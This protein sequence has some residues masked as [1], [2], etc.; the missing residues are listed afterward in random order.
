MR[1]AESDGVKICLSEE[2]KKQISSYER[3]KEAL[4]KYR[5]SWQQR[6]EGFYETET[7]KPG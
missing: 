6:K 2:Q 3:I 1:F 5:M 4:G 7:S